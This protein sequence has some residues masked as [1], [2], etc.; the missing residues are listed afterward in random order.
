[1]AVWRNWI[2]LSGEHVY[3]QFTRDTEVPVTYD[4]LDEWVPD[5]LEVPW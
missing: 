5:L 4:I 1:M 3:V 2:A